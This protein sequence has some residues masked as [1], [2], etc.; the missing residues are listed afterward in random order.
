MHQPHFASQKKFGVEMINPG[1]PLDA[2]DV[3]A[4]VHL[5]RALVLL[6]FSLV[7]LTRALVPLGF[8]GIK[9]PLQKKRKLKELTSLKFAGPPADFA[10]FPL[11]GY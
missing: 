8:S 10:Y 2:F 11:F 1:L 7:H 4:L 6:G 9:C 3:D 5:A